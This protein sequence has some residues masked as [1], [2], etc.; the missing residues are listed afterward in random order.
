MFSPVSFSLSSLQNLYRD[1]AGRIEPWQIVDNVLVSSAAIQAN[2]DAGSLHIF[3]PGD[4]DPEFIKRRSLTLNLPSA[5]EQHGRQ[6]TTDDRSFLDVEQLDHE[7]T[8][9]SQ[10]SKSEDILSQ[11]DEQLSGGSS[12]SSV[13]FGAI[14]P[15][16]Y[17]EKAYVPFGYS[18]PGCEDTTES[19]YAARQDVPFSD[20]ERLVREPARDSQSPRDRDFLFADVEQR[21]RPIAVEPASQDLPFLSAEHLNCEPTV[22]PSPTSQVVQLLDSEQFCGNPTTRNRSPTGQDVSDPL[23]QEFTTGS[24]S[25]PSPHVSPLIDESLSQSTP[26]DGT[27]EQ[28]T[29]E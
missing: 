7:S 17:V 23:D 29:S 25:P 16:G 27:I 6:P 18:G 4:L 1:P 26:D 10:S 24:R 19:P 2:V 11:S 3:Q 20:V 21:D 12:T 8:T 14:G 9:E 28:L 13:E 22:S 5:G 15:R